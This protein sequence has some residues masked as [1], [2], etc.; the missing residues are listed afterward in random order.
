MAFKLTDE[1]AE[2]VA[3][4]AKGTCQSEAEI[5]EAF[6]FFKGV[7]DNEALDALNEALADKEVARCDTCS[8]WVESSELNEDSNCEDCAAAE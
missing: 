6:D 5:M 8:W 4:Y 7:D 2:K 1:Q 3:D